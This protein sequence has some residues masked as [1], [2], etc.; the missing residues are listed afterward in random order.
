MS[1]SHSFNVKSLIK[2]VRKHWR[3][4]I[5]CFVILLAAVAMVL[6]NGHGADP[7]Y[8]GKPL[9][10]WLRVYPM[11]FPGEDQWRVQHMS[12]AVR[13]EMYRRTF[14][15]RKGNA[16]LGEDI[17]NA[18]EALIHCGQTAFPLLIEKIKG[19]RDFRILHYPTVEA[20]R[21]WLELTETIP[22]RVDSFSERGAAVTMFLDLQESGC[23]MQPALEDLKKLSQSPDAQI[24]TCARCI[25]KA[26]EA[27]K[28]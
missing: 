12:A 14:R 27:G 16:K 7:I 5:V 17:A 23:D 1:L 13:R 21:R 6:S 18:H 26:L 19:P 24:S 11:T 2:K 9:S 4:A 22:V 25:L 28:K 20:T 10:V 8:N 15:D 3:L